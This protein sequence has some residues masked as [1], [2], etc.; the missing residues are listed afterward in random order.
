MNFL[1]RIIATFFGIGYLRPAPGTWGSLA[2]LPIGVAV[3]IIFGWQALLALSLL[4]FIIGVWASGHY[5]KT[6]DT[7]DP[8]EVVIDEV[9]GQWLALAFVAP[10]L[11]EVIAAFA[12][13]RLFDIVKPW[14]IGRLERLPGGLGI[15]SDDMLAG[16]VAGVLILLFRNLPIL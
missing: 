4:T 8:S 7:K 10:V 12:L 14:L 3:L 13:F 6:I 1:S 5:A 9:A 15:M 11:W 16:L 2:A